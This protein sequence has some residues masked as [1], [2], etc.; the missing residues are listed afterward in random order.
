MSGIPK[1]IHQLWKTDQIPRRWVKAVRSVRRCHPG[2]EY[3]LWT[4][5]KMEVHVRD[6]HPEIYETYMGFDL[7]IMRADIFR[8]IL[9]YDFGGMYCDLDYEFVRPFD[10][11]NEELVLSLEYDKAYGDG[12]NQLANFVF[13]SVPQHKLWQEILENIRLFPPVI[14]G[15]LDVCVATGPKLVTRCFYS[16]ENGHPR[17]KL[18]HQPVLSPRRVHGPYERKFYIN[19]GVTY[20]FH[21]GW[22]SW[23]GRWNFGYLKLRLTKILRLGL[24][25]NEQRKSDDV[26]FL[27]N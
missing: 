12:E 7:N 27:Q 15:N 9:M 16:D 18:T 26:D 10:Y 14:S 5:E 11:E 1:I 19:S 8:Y 3:R 23:R 17:A 21:H 25:P 20:G 13:A 22:G 2:W 24:G 4:D 6:H